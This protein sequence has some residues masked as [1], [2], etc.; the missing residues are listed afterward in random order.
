MST[1]ARFSPFIYIISRE[2]CRKDIK[3]TGAHK[4]LRGFAGLTFYLD[5]VWALGAWCESRNAMTAL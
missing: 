4:S 1:C 3:E 2:I 5:K